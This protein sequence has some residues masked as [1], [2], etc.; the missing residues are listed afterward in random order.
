[1]LMTE[2]D[3]DTDIA[4]QREEAFNEGAEQAKL[5]TARNMLKNDI[6]LEIVAQCTGLSLEK[7]KELSES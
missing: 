5:E 4:V 1:M 3:Y 7:V 6:S 2:Y